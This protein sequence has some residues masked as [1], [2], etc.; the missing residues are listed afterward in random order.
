MRYR[1]RRARTASKL[2]LAFCAGAGRTGSGG[3]LESL[4][5]DVLGGFTGTYFGVASPVP[6][7]A[8]IVGMATWRVRTIPG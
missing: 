8:R 5:G 3:R 1:R 2:M 6:A 4:G 7:R